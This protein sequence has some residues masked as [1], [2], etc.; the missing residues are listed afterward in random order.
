MQALGVIYKASSKTGTRYSLAFSHSE[1]SLA[2]KMMKRS[3]Q[4]SRSCL[5]SSIGSERVIR[6]TILL[7]TY[8]KDPCVLQL[9]KRSG[10]SAEMVYKKVFITKLS[11]LTLPCRFQVNSYQAG[12][13]IS[14][15]HLHVLFQRS[16][17]ANHVIHGS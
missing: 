17:F 2:V 1:P 13:Q 11:P 7:L 5:K 12:A 3:C 14:E 15:R 16:S 9:Q 6:N 8:T 4:S 10:G